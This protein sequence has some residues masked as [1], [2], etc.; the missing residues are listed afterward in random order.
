MGPGDDEAALAREETVISTL[1]AAA[2][3]VVEA[4]RLECAG[5][6]DACEGGED[7]AGG[8]EQERLHACAKILAGISAAAAL[9]APEAQPVPPSPDSIHTADKPSKIDL[10]RAR[11]GMH[12]PADGGAA[13]A[14]AVSERQR[15]HDPGAS[16]AGERPPSLV[17]P[18]QLE[19]LRV[20]GHQ[21]E[22][23]LRSAL[24]ML[25][26]QGLIGRGV[27][28]SWNPCMLGLKLIL[29]VSPSLPESLSFSRASFCPFD[30]RVAIM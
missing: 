23:L 11:K 30:P 8:R 2:V 3:R 29:A 12:A 24:D 14:A 6:G 5:P 7:F 10:F 22:S 25:S 1:V 19:K 20:K 27:G 28:V 16:A 4:R 26:D 18:S 13:A 21:V 17:D 15:R 9:V